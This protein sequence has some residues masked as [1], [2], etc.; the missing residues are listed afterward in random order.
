M[1]APRTFGGLLVSVLA[2]HLLVVGVF[3]ANA[4]EVISRFMLPDGGEDRSWAHPVVCGGRLYIRHNEFLYAYDV[5]SYNTIVG[6]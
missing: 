3:A 1:H 5:R 4:H 2:L 6:E